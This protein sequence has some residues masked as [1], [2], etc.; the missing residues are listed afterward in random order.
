MSSV[1]DL[2][3]DLI[4]RD[5]ATVRK[6]S[7]IV[8]HPESRATQGFSP[9]SPLSPGGAVAAD[10]AP[11]HPCPDCGSN[12]FYRAKRGGPW[13]CWGCRPPERG[14]VALHTV[15]GGK[16]PGGEAQDIDVVLA[17]AVDG[18]GISV[19]DLRQVMDADDIADVA[20]GA[21]GVRVLRYFAQRI[22][23][24]VNRDG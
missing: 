17:A 5:F 10:H 7:P 13:I 21:I 11:E 12:S 8:R 20:A 3:A 15:P 2:V 6:D 9:D 22:A 16:V 14:P 4:G 24:G 18:L 1:M 19:E 23:K